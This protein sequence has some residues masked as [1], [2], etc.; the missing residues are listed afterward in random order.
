MT[1]M[2][3]TRMPQDNLQKNV[4]MGQKELPRESIMLCKGCSQDPET[5]FDDLPCITSSLQLFSEL[6][7]ISVALQ[8]I[9]EG[10]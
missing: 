2:D 9:M 1:A 10:S 5:H 4:N 3:D 8:L 6:W 7:Y